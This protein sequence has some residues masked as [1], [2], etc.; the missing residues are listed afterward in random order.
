MPRETDSQGK[1]LATDLADVL[2]GLLLRVRHQHVLL[3]VVHAD[4]LDAHGALD[5]GHSPGVDPLHVAVQV[6]GLLEL[7]VAV[8]ARVR[9]PGLRVHPPK[10][11]S[12]VLGGDKLARTHS[13]SEGLLAS[14]SLLM[15]S[16]IAEG[17]AGLWADI[18]LERLL[19]A[20]VRTLV[21]TEKP[22]QHELFRAK[23]TRIRSLSGMRSDV[24][25]QIL[26]AFERLGTQVALQWPALL[27]RVSNVP[28]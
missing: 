13:A 5:P 28:L 23:L 21:G 11:T 18:A 19:A 2:V 8:R 4:G 26:R 10:V 17:S 22:R 12:Q 6:L 24:V 20:G 14:V 7:L 27:V 3:E 25:L 16:Q 9:L 1:L 15:T